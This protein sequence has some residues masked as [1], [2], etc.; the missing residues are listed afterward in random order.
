[1][2]VGT[3]GATEVPEKTDKSA[4]TTADRKPAQDDDPVKMEEETAGDEQ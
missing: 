3:V 1:M 2:W 4:G